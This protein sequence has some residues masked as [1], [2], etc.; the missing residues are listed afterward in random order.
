M[1]LT[2]IVSYYKALTNLKLVLLGFENQSVK[3]FEV[4]ISEDDFNPETAKFI[5]ENK[6]NYSFSIQ[7]LYQEQDNG[8]RKNEMLNRSIKASKSSVLAFLDGDCIPH[9]NLVKEFIKH[10]DGKHILAGRRVLLGPVISE[11][12]TKEVS[13]EQL[14]L[15]A[16]YR[17][18]TKHKK[19]AIYSPFLSFGSKVRGLLGCNWAVRKEYLL[20]ING[21]DEDYISPGV[22]ED[23]DIEWRLQAI[24][25]T[26]KRMKNKAIVFHV[27][28]E[29][30]YSEDGV[31]ANYKILEKK[32]ETGK[33]RCLNGIEK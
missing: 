23:V 25:L 31:Q 26:K 9:K 12:L 27:H 4:I 29:R 32:Q 13:I 14:K 16:I 18:N 21:Y 19:E 24:G 6:A 2:A 30:S 10:G 5:E 20:E 7:H 8:F 28:H 17:S 1:K 33:I 22:G 3:D 11:T 15:S